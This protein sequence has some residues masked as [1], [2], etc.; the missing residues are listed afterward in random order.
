M[1]IVFQTLSSHNSLS[2]VFLI[3]GHDIRKKLVCAFKA[4]SILH[5]DCVYYLKLVRYPKGLENRLDIQKFWEFFFKFWTVRLRCAF[6]STSGQWVWWILLRPYLGGVRIAQKKH[7]EEYVVPPCGWTPSPPPQFSPSY[8][9]EFYVHLQ[10]IKLLDRFMNLNSDQQKIL[11]QQFFN[12]FF[13]ESTVFF[14][15]KRIGF[16]K[17]QN[18]LFIQK[19]F[20]MLATF[21]LYKKCFLSY[22]S[23]KKVQIL[24]PKIWQVLFYFFFVFLVTKKFVLVFDFWVNI[25]I[26]FLWINPVIDR[27]WLLRFQV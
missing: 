9:T 17:W 6:L 15:E 7:K 12:C 14:L 26:F 18:K 27:P 23:Y 19:L 24:A 4:F 20:K 16:K 21:D 25:W 22:F 13:F 2:N 8:G 3:T 11:N 5:S 10:Q 1:M